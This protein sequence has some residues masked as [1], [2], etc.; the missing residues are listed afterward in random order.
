MS[1]AAPTTEQTPSI[2]YVGVVI[3]AT[4]ATQEIA[5]NWGWILAAG[6][7]SVVGGV[8]ALMAP[9]LATGVTATFIAA[10]LLVVGCVNLAGV[11]YAEKGLKLESFLTGVVQV[12]LSAVMA[13][14]P[15]A[16]LMSMTMLI[17]AFMLA[18][19]IIRSVLA[20][21]NRDLAG[22]GWTLAGGLA[23]IATSVIVVTALPGASFW[24]IGVLVGVNLISIGVARIGVAL[25]GRKIANATA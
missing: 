13:F 5:K 8:A 24:V 10:T 1:T 25:E 12:L 15:F 21:Q 7:I 19:G 9:V 17:A 16:S 22:W 14:Y 11:F 20:V 23:S 6:I 3:D 2:D 4:K 18:D